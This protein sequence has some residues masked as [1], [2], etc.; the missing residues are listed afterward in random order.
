MA[1]T[2]DFQLIVETHSEY[3][4]RKMQ[5]LFAANIKENNIA[6]DELNEKID[7]LEQILDLCGSYLE[8]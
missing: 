4:V 3:L 6:E 7:I 5:V 2:H 8:I 1:I